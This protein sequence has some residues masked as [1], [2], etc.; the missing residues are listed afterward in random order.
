M[1]GLTPVPDD[2]ALAGFLGERIA[3]DWI[4]CNQL[5]EELDD[6]IN[7]TEIGNIPVEFAYGKMLNKFRD[8]EPHEL[9]NIAAAAM[10][11]LHGQNNAVV[12]VIRTETDTDARPQDSKSQSFSD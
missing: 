8:I 2:S 5:L 9:V 4:A 1:S 11:R 6:T 7:D 10:W 3:E 12:T